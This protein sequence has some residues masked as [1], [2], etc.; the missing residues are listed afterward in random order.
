[1]FLFPSVLIWSVGCCVLLFVYLLPAKLA[2]PIGALLCQIVERGIWFGVLS[3]LTGNRLHTWFLITLLNMPFNFS[4]KFTISII[5]EYKNKYNNIRY[6][7]NIFIYFKFGFCTPSKNA[8]GEVE[9]SKFQHVFFSLIYRV[10]SYCSF[11]CLFVIICF[12]FL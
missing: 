3:V 12:F 11:L 1:M 5:C 4:S 8:F 7:K 2:V 6:I 9:T 10:F